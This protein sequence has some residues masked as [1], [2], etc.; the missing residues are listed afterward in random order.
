MAEKD[1]KFITDFCLSKVESLGP[2]V[3]FA[4]L[5]RSGLPESL[6]VY[7]SAEIDYRIFTDRQRLLIESSFDYSG[8]KISGYFN[9][10]RNEIKQN[11]R[12]PSEEILHSLNEAVRFNN[13]FVER[14]RETI[15]NF[16]FQ[17]TRNRTVP[18]IK[19]LLAYTHYYPF[20]KNIVYGFI[21]KKRL[22]SVSVN[23]FSELLS[24]IFNLLKET[25][26]KYLLECSLSAI[27]DFYNMGST[28]KN[29]IPLSPF[30]SF[31]KER[32]LIEQLNRLYEVFGDRPKPR[33][34]LKDV[35]KI[36]DA[37]YIGKF[38]DIP[39]DAATASVSKADAGDVILE[40]LQ[41]II[42]SYESPIGAEIPVSEPVPEARIQPVGQGALQENQE[43]KEFQ[44]DEVQAGETE[45]SDT[46]EIVGEEEVIERSLMPEISP[47]EFVFGED[48][49]QGSSKK[50]ETD[51]ASSEADP[52]LM[53][54]VGKWGMRKIIRVLFKGNKALASE[55]LSE[56][57]RAETL[58]DAFQLTDRHIM[59]Y[60]ISGA[61]EETEA[62]KKLL[63]RYFMEHRK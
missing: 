47:A 46:V 26:K 9:Q 16:I 4:D 8:P 12:F 22:L 18:E 28:D 10:I 35:R 42:T 40:D 60:K 7:V 59:R 52:E 51:W 54:L 14:P 23:Q 36:I 43:E 25:E 41:D 24:R 50:K 2:L 56:I 17:K 20:I 58:E 15:L 34:S 27:S 32:N 21:D 29:S 19:Q 44:E 11:K 5:K 37:E 39:V 61:Y 31:L 49:Q 6:L 3:T 48:E 13:S 30:E 1:I 57:S 53:K 62:F 45:P 63:A 33:L 38:N 55:L